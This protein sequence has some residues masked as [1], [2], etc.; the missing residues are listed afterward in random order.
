[1]LSKRIRGVLT[2]CLLLL[3]IP[4]SSPG[5]I[6][7]IHEDITDEAIRA[8]LANN[9]NLSRL[10]FARE[11]LVRAS[12]DEDFLHGGIPGTGGHHRAVDHFDSNPDYPS[13]CNNYAVIYQ[14]IDRTLKLVVPDPVEFGT[15]LHAIED[16]YS[17][18]NYV[19]LYETFAE[20]HPSASEFPP[21]I[22]EVWLHPSDYA[23]FIASLLRDL[24]T[25]WYPNRKDVAAEANHGLPF[26]PLSRGM[27]IDYRERGYAPYTKA[28]HAAQRAAIWYLRLYAGDQQARQEWTQLRGACMAAPLKLDLGLPGIDRLMDRVRS[29]PNPSERM[30]DAL[31]L[32]RISDPKGVAALADAVSR[33]PS[34]AVKRQAAQA[35]SSFGS[36]ASAEDAILRLLPEA[37][38]VSVKAEL[39]RSLG[40]YRSERAKDVLLQSLASPTTSLQTAALQALVTQGDPAV[41]PE[42][43]LL[44]NARLPAVAVRAAWALGEL[45]SGHS[46]PALLNALTHGRPELRTVS[47]R[48]L[49][50]IEDPSAI[51]S[52]GALAQNREEPPSVRVAAI[53]ALSSFGEERASGWLR[54]LLK[55]PNDEV[56]SCAAYLL[57]AL[58][59][60]D[61]APEAQELLGSRNLM[62]RN[63]VLAATG[64]WPEPFLQQLARLASTGKDD[65]TRLMA[66]NSL[67]A[68]PA[69]RSE[70]VRPVLRGLLSLRESADI[71]FAA[72][73]VLSVN[74]TPADVNA[75]KQ[76]TQT[77]GLNPHVKAA[78]VTEVP[79]VVNVTI[80]EA[81]KALKEAGLEKGSVHEIPENR[82]R[83]LVVLQI[84]SGGV[85]RSFNYQVRLYVSSGP[86]PEG[87]IDVPD[88]VGLNKDEAFSRLGELSLTGQ[89]LP[90]LTDCRP[91]DK[92]VFQ[93]P[94][95][96]KYD[97]EPQ[98][99]IAKG[100]TVYLFLSDG[101]PTDVPAD[102]T[103]QD[104]LA[105][106]RWVDRLRKSKVFYLFHG[107]GG[108]GATGVI[109]GQKPQGGS[110]VPCGT[111]VHV[112]YR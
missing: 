51:T 84:P 89:D 91:G 50:R 90:T 38:P 13:F 82:P 63:A 95:A 54:P 48:A 23:D 10:S 2:V 32:G 47:A 37:H 104:K 39:I 65:K 80:E 70:E 11:P 76:F 68:V 9:P 59:D 77:Q 103:G 53:R 1:M 57:I 44:L 88:L 92:V 33:D 78:L 26:Y 30:A 85:F 5:F 34:P 98:P 6:T 7:W 17:H 111:V 100:G 101:H 4:S 3:L 35:L 22:E 14:R 42:I 94:E 110:K 64:L 12:W 75:L 29:G 31:L 8:I 105:A 112:T 18:S 20:R 28:R 96:W 102:L 61:A 15:S 66:L 16:I 69:S 81:V 71:Q 93:L 46:V 60:R 41:S 40:S 36:D 49:G 19:S 99:K 97:Q 43:E 79:Q 87:S 106:L 25:G 86:A 109:T 67:S 58:H 62:V 55:D 107:E 108:T 52:L 73:Q 83:G 45:R 74:P 24:H 56:R 72:V 21:P 27:N